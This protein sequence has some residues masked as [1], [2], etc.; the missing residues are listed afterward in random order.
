MRTGRKILYATIVLAILITIIQIFRLAGGYEEFIFA[1]LHHGTWGMFYNQPWRML[2]SPFI[3]QDI[4]HYFENLLFLLLFGFQIERKHGW[5]YTLG[6]FFGA[7]TTGY[8]FQVTVMHTGII[9]ISGGVCGLF[10]FSLIANRRTPWWTTLTH[11]PLHILYTLNLSWALFADTL[12]LIPN[13]V[14]HLNHLVGILYGV[15]F[16]SAFLLGSHNA[17]WRGAVIALPMLL[18]VSQ[19]YSPW[20]L[21]WQLVQRQADLIAE[22]PDCQL[23]S[24]VQETAVPAPITFVNSTANRVAYYWLDYEGKAIFYGWLEPGNSDEMNSFV[25]HPWCFVDID[26]G[27]ALQAVT[28]TEPG[29]TLIIR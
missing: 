18:F 7:L 9:G 10:G 19:F 17:K 12:D 22:N 3:H 4:P 29:Q 11:R 14:A 25:G 6:A 15:L 27:K 1:N 26:N 23:E 21:E 2:T 16:G 5:K 8:V 28:V 20:Q 24:I 13:D